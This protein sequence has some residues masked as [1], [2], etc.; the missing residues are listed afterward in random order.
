MNYSIELFR[1]ILM[2]VLI[3]WHGQFGFFCHGYL[4]VEFFFILSGFFLYRSYLRQQTG[5]VDFT[6]RRLKRTYVVY[7]IA[8]FM[9]FA[10]QIFPRILTQPHLLSVNDFIKLL[11]ELLLMQNI[12]IYS[13]GYNYPLWYYSVLIW[14][15]AIWYAILRFNAKACVNI[16]LPLFVLSYYS[17]HFG[18]YD[19]LEVWGHHGIYVPFFRGLADMGTGILLACLVPY[20][21]VNSLSKLVMHFMTITSLPLFAYLLYAQASYDKYCLIL[22]PLILLDCIH[23]D[24]LLGKLLNRRVFSFMGGVSFEMYVLHF[25]LI[26]LFNKVKNVCGISASPLSV[27]VVYVVLITIISIFFKKLC[28]KMECFLWKKNNPK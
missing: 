7:L 26:L 11:P 12:G 23:K 5:C 21:P 16:V 25:P 10:L 4:V 28:N 8:C 17:W 13:G 15:G 20:V 22:I 3:A 19:S 9:A 27:F 14:G 24:G 18:N 6:K 1:Y 2:M